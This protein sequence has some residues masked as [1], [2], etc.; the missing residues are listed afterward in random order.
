MQPFK[1][2]KVYDGDN[3][4]FVQYHWSRIEGKYIR[5]KARIGFR[6]LDRDFRKMLLQNL[7]DELNVTFKIRNKNFDYLDEATEL[8]ISVAE[9][10]QPLTE[11]IELTKKDPDIEKS[12]HKSFSELNYR[13]VESNTNLYP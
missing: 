3:E 5:K 6:G 7:C 10:I 12:W 13:M 8:N 2:A 1:R 4:W 11:W 9:A